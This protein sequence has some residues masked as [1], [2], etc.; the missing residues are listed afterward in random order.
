MRKTV[1]SIP[2]PPS[3]QSS[4]KQKS[5]CALLKQ[6]FLE[7]WFLLITFLYRS[8]ANLALDITKLCC[9]A[10]YYITRKY[11]DISGSFYRSHL[12]NE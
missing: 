7:M 6:F 3:L 9:P 2:S 12:H 10:D 5:A 1:S 8:E 11:S 4:V